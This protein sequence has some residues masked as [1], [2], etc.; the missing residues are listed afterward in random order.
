MGRCDLKKIKY[1]KVNSNF[2]FHDQFQRSVLV[3]FAQGVSV[4]GVCVL[5]GKCPRGK[6][7]G[8]ICPRGYM[9]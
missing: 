8:G 1:Y 6:C 2:L 9:S 3:L 7:P 4:Q 5:G